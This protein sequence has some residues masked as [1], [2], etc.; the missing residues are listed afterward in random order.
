MALGWRTSIVVD[1]EV[2]RV[3]PRRD[4][5][6]PRSG[7]ERFLERQQSRMANEQKGKDEKARRRRDRKIYALRKGRS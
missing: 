3:D 2:D 7:R 1:E 5:D 4:P 6:N